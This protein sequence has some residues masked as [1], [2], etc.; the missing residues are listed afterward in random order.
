[1]LVLFL[2]QLPSPLLL[3]PGKTE[4]GFRAFVSTEGGETERRRCI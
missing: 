3:S 1:M 2:A 4:V